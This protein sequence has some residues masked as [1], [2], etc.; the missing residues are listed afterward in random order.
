MSDRSA[1]DWIKDYSAI[2]VSVATAFYVCGYLVHVAYFRVLG[3]EIDGQPLDYI[4]MGGDYSISLITSTVQLVGLFS[5][6]SY[7]NQE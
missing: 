5:Q 3:V 6:Y 4:K 1:L 2:V 7:A